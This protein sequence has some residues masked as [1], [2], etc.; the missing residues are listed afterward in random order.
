MSSAT[1]T[2]TDIGPA[3]EPCVALTPI[4]TSLAQESLVALS[5]INTS[6]AHEIFGSSYSYKHCLAW[7]SFSM[8]LPVVLVWLPMYPFLSLKLHTHR[9][10][11]RFR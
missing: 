6:L 10:Q 3:Q 11:F 9:G 4:H 1:L 5:P 8:R 2:P 7:V